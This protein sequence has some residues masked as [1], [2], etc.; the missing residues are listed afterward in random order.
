V[1]KSAVVTFHA[2][3]LYPEDANSLHDHKRMCSPLL[4]SARDHSVHASAVL[5]FHAIAL[6]PEDAHSLAWTPEH[7]LRYTS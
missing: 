1:Q 2:H 3:A 7:M 4:H 5:A 6:F